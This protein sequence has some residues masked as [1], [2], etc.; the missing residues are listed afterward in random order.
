MKLDQIVH[1]VKKQSPVILAV[2]AGIGV[3]ATA[4]AAG[5][6]SVHA[7]RIIENEHKEDDTALDD[8]KRVWREYIPTAVIG[9]TT[10]ACIGAGTKISIDRVASFATAYTLV[11]SNLTELASEIPEKI[12]EQVKENVAKK[13]VEKNPLTDIVD[14][15]PGTDGPV[16]CMDEGS[17]RYFWSDLQT[18]RSI[19]NDLNKQLVAHTWVPLNSL[20][21]ALDMPSIKMG[22]KL[23]W[24]S[25]LIEFNFTTILTQDDR[26]CLVLSYELDPL[27]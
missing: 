26:P 15:L 8:F 21:S 16:L 13:K 27:F 4:I 20:Y 7:S 3:V 12:Q 18:L 19:E 11:R 1:F 2:T 22:D 23:G 17:G 10:I 6:A 14:V 5:K 9:A 25:D 24:S